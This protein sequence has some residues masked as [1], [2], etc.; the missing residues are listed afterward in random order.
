[1]NDNCNCVKSTQ[2]DVLE[3]IQ[4]TTPTLTLNL[5]IDLSQG[6]DLRLAVKSGIET[7]F[8][9]TNENMTVVPNQCGCTIMAKFTQEQTFAMSKSIRVQLRAKQIATS[10]V[11]GTKEVEVDIIRSLDDEVM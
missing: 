8:V 7:I 5:A 10:D 4:G 3:I 9:L 1:M 6:Y 11:I 2:A